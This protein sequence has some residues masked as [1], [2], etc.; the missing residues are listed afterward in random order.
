MVDARRLKISR[1]G[2]MW[3][4]SGS[5]EADADL[6]PINQHD[7]TLRINVRHLNSINSVGVRALCLFLKDFAGESFEYYE[8]RPN[9]LDVINMVPMLLKVDGKLGRVISMNVPYV[10]NRCL[11]EINILTQTSEIGKM[12]HAVSLPTYDC[13]QCNSP[14][15]LEPAMPPQDLLYFMT[16]QIPANP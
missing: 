6:A 3:F 4:L 11:Y 14:S 8:C 12:G 1:K 16:N 7:G 13:S 2:D 15:A 9:F 5:L 10:C